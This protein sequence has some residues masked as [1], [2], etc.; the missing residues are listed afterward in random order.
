MPS[1]ADEPSPTLGGPREQPWGFPEAL[2]R[3]HLAVP[4][5]RQRQPRL[6]SS[7]A[8]P[9]AAA[10]RRPLSPR[11]G[12]ESS[13]QRRQRK[14][15]AQPERAAGA[16]APSRASRPRPGGSGGRAPQ[17]VTRAGASRRG[18]RPLPGRGELSA[19]AAMA[20]WEVSETSFSLSGV[21]ERMREKKKGPLK[22]A[23]LS[24]SLASKIKT[25]IINNSSTI[26]VSLKHNNK[27]LALAL[28]A[29]K[30]NAQR[31]TQEKTILQKEVKQCHF[32]NAVLRHKL[33]FLFQTSSASLSHGQQ[34]SVTEDSWADSIADD[35][36]MRAPGIP[37]R[38]PISKLCNARQ[39]GGSSTAVLTSSLDLQRPASNEP[40]EVVPVASKDILSLQPAEKPQSHQEENGKKL[41]G[42]EAQEAFLDS[43][44]FGV[45][46]TDPSCATQ[47]NPN[48]L[49]ALAW[50][51]HPLSYEGDEMVK[52]VFDHLSQGH[53]TQRK[54]R[55][56][57]FATSTPSSSV[58]DTFPHV[59]S[60]WPAQWSITKD[61]SSSNKSNTQLQLKSPTC[62]V[63]P[64][65]NTVIPDRK[66]LGEEIFC[67]QSQAKGTGCSVETDRSYNQVPEVV[68]VKG[69]SK[70]NS[71]T[72][73]KTTVKK[74]STRKKKT[75]ANKNN[76]ESS[77][78]IPQ[79]EESAQSV[80]KLL[81]PEV[82]TCSS[83]P[84]FFE[85]RKKGAIDRKNGSCGVEQHSHSPDEIKDLRR[86]CV[87]NPAQLH[88][89]G[90]GDLL[91]Q[92]KKGAVFEI[93]SMESLSKSPVT[94]LSSHE[95]SD[96][97]SLQNALFLRKEAS[98]A[99]ASQEDLSMSTKSIRQKANTKTTVI[100]QRDDSEEYLPRSV[101]IPEAKAEE[102]PKKTQ[103][104]RKNTVRKSSCDQRKEADGFGACIDVQG[105]AKESTKDF[106][107]DLKRSRKTYVVH[108]LA[109]PGE[110]GCVQTDCEGGETVSP[111]PVASSK[112]S[113]I[114]RVLRMVAV[115][116]NKKQTGGLQ[117]KGQGKV[118]SDVNASKIEA[119]TQPEPQRKR[120]SSRPPETD[121]LARQSDGAKAHIG[122]SVELASRQT[123]LMD[124]F[125]F[126]KDLLSEPGALLEKIAEIPLTNN[127]MDLSHSL[128]STSVT[129][130]AA[131]R[132]GSRLTD[133]P[134]SKSLST[135]GNRMPE[136]S[137][138]LPASS[139]ILKGK[140]AK[141][142]PG[143]RNQ[144]ESSFQSSSSQEPEIR[145]LQDLTNV[146]TLSSCSSEEM[147][148]R[149]SKRRREPACYKEPKLNSKLR[150][151]DPFT[152]MEFFYSPLKKPKKTTTCQMTKKIKEEKVWLPE[153]CPSA[154]AGKLVTTARDME[155][156]GKQ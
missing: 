52:N 91:Q 78:V 76:E 55:S 71:K 149:L 60:T 118:D 84:D 70:S 104:S 77:S 117:E 15:A 66:S 21:R 30:A 10:F 99:C 85:M 65:Q 39:Q 148:R 110:L 54:K 1:S 69:K 68:P 58:V 136:K 120:N 59:S 89:P 17:P 53:V 13:P 44:V 12:A 94:T 144:V 123:V 112:A 47:Q 95:V 73:E 105:V 154:K 64:T 34:S 61:S 114:P 150:R 48:D 63:S 51:S 23:K 83:E 19:G 142:I 151:G 128:E 14:M 74:A 141:E 38:V 130:S 4:G 33:S 119:Y 109:L 2:Q 86:T 96:Y 108:P 36:L 80:N 67:D 132:L 92:V 140:P 25:K 28:N 145:P 50:E 124:K 116:R 82:A 6:T 156:E 11:T 107:G 113:K 103:T 152:N 153:G 32:Q 62:L 134:V 43:C 98:G 16:R 138:V 111:R 72:G 122:S 35:Q 40:L 121:S 29:E 115:Q 42:M 133:V 101:Q 79:G 93:Q 57:L 146:R 143:E 87:V 129:C 18:R 7:A 126:I 26:K 20:A 88:S 49:P 22:N 97:S 127:L 45:F 5:A 56:T 37:M 24:A 46:P 100:G 31:L 8:A 137:S 139:P 27:A 131:S 41:T 125:S 90:S 155:S 9:G 81:Q 75:N 102:R 135:K 106:P 147:S 3:L